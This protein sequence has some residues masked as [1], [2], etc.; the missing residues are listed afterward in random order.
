VHRAAGVET[1]RLRQ[2]QRLHDD[3]LAGERG[4]AV[5]LH[6]QHLVAELI[7]AP[8]L[9]RAHRAFDHRVHDFQMRRIEGQATCTL[10]LGVFRSERN[11]CG[12]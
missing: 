3:A 8:L 10:P 4:I 1:A 7:A 9:P 12:T 5:N 11:P 6:R 2:L